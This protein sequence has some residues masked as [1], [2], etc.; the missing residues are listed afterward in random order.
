MNIVKFIESIEFRDLRYFIAVAEQGS[1]SRAAEQ[2][3]IAQPYLTKQ[4]KALEKKLKVCL[5]DR[6]KRPLQLTQTGRAF[7]EEALAIRE[8]LEQAA[9]KLERIDQ[10]ELGCLKVSFTSAMANGILPNILRDFKRN[11]PNVKLILSE[12]NSVSQAQRLRDH[13]TDIM[14]FYQEWGLAEAKGLEVIPLLQEPLVA[15]LFHQHALASRSEILLTDLMSE[16]FIMP[17]RQVVPGLFEQIYYLCS[18]AGFVPNVVQE[19]IFMVTILG[20]VAGEVGISILPA[21]VNNLQRKGVVYL[22]IQGQ[23]ISNQLC[24]VWRSDDSS[25]ILPHF[26]DSVRT[27]LRNYKK[28]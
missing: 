27:V 11:H 5:L 12:E 16:E 18:Q 24:V 22:P 13:M 21:S 4:M 9:Q 20:L 3:Q 19:A 25:T 15:V 10:G 23:T 6:T 17:D 7:L 26:L 1:V 14:F 8:I 2:L 28:Y